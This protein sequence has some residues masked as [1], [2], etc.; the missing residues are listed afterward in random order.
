MQTPLRLAT[1]NAMVVLSDMQ[2]P[3]VAR[4]SRTTPERDLRKA[5]SILSE[6]AG[7]LGIPLFG[8]VIPLGAGESGTEA[9]DELAGQR[10]MVRQTVGVFD[11][12]A[13]RD[14]IASHDRPIIAIGG[15]STEVAALHAVLGALRIGHAVHVLTDACGGFD[16][17]TEAAAFRQMEEAGATMSSVPSFLTAMIGSLADADGQAVLASLSRFWSEDSELVAPVVPV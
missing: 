5:V 12:D 16:A 15:V 17:R 8:S 3:I 10:C 1:T 14:A 4:G 7:I 6:S 9:I 11:D 2:P 13:T